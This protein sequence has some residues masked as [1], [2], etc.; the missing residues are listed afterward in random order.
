[1]HGLCREYTVRNIP[2][3]SSKETSLAGHSLQHTENRLFGHMT[4]SSLTE[5]AR[6]LSL[7]SQDIGSSL[8][9]ARIYL[10]FCSAPF[11]YLEN[12]LV[13]AEIC[14]SV[15]SKSH[16]SEKSARSS[17]VL[18]MIA[19]E[20]QSTVTTQ[21]QDQGPKSV[22]KC[23]QT[24]R[25][26]AESVRLLS[27]ELWIRTFSYHSL[28][29]WPFT[30]SFFPFLYK[31]TPFETAATS[32]MDERMNL[33]FIMERSSVDMYVKG[34]IGV[35]RLE[36]G[37][38]PDEEGP[39]KYRKNGIH[40][41]HISDLYK[42]SRY[43]I[44]H[45]LGSGGCATV[46]LARDQEQSRNVALKITTAKK[47]AENSETKMLQYLAVPSSEHPGKQHLAMLLDHFEF[48]GPNGIHT[49]LVLPL[50][51]PCVAMMAIAQK[52]KTL[53]QGVAWKVAFQLSEGLAY[54]HSVGVG[55]GGKFPLRT[56]REVY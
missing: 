20:V 19:C 22:T 15:M 47:T 46:W 39:T 17:L 25:F 2:Y 50:L 5:V 8:N 37:D 10:Y 34:Q 6:C 42:R 48:E 1:M 18:H 27:T 3:R 28:T 13:F 53:D 54:L 38:T 9:G 32:Q 43:R 23:V 7:I 41:T 29:A 21:P 52:T 33:C 56:F 16:G 35:R 30:A 51:G 31:F 40:P 36:I 26:H 55:H 49:C 24:R 12:L 11:S 14:R 4:L 44:I 45:K